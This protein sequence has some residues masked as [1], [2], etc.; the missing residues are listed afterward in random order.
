MAYTG[1]LAAFVTDWLTPLGFAHGYLYVPFALVAGMSRRPNH[2]ITVSLIGS[3]L[4]VAGGLLSLLPMPAFPSWIYITNRAVSIATIAVAAIVAL[5]LIRYDAAL[6]DSNRDLQRTK[7]LLDERLQLLDIASEAAHIGGWCYDLDTEQVS[8]SNEV[9]RIH[10]QEPGFQPT[11]DQAIQFYAPEYRER[12]RGLLERCGMSGQPFDEEMQIIIDGGQRIWVRV[13][14]VQVRE[15][16]GRVTAIQGAFQ[17]IDLRM[18]AQEETRQMSERL[19]STLENISDGFIMLDKDWRLTFINLHGEAMVNRTRN[20]LLGK[21]FWKIFPEAVGSPFES[22]YKGAV[23]RNQSVNFEEYF[24]PLKT[25]FGVSAYPSDEGLAIYFRDITHLKSLETQLQEAQRLEAVG[26]LTGG[27]AHDFNNLLTVV[28][29][30]AE[31]LAESLDDKEEPLE[32]VHSIQSAANRGADLTKSLL[33][34]ARRQPLQPKAVDAVALVHG[35][36]TLLR[37]AVGED[38]DLK[39]NAEQ[40]LRLVQVD[41]AQLESALLNLALNARDAMPDGGRLTVELRPASLDTA[42]AG[43]HPDVEPGNYVLL[44]ITDTG[45]G[46]APQNLPKLFEP[47]YTTKERSKGS[48]LGLSMVFGFVKQSGGHVAVYSE[49][50]VGTSVRMYLPPSEGQEAARMPESSDAPLVGGSETILLVEDDDLVRQFAVQQLRQVGYTVLDAPHGPAALAIMQS[51]DEPIDL[52]FTDVIMPGGMSGRVLADEARLLQPDLKVLFSSGY[53]ETAILHHGR[54]DADVSL[55][56]KPY[57]R[58]E[59]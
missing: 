36:E 5:L 11:A 34:F 30:N 1:L 45:V 57:R 17:D 3:A 46:I 56:S 12:I 48:G 43:G 39:I 7:S 24:P 14:G 25:W 16:S 42:Y 31:L 15:G 59:L 40:N 32:L 50:D 18:L 20:E 52:L 54:L 27:I 22:H 33:A 8:W 55:L 51:H 2:V 23:K 53:T 21:S 47:F 38:I 49:V 44:V 26:Q 35:L 19:R 29:G 10:R 13:I 37:R 28:I 4:I 58:A 6:R 9:A 41:P